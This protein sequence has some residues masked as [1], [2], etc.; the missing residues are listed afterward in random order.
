MHLLTLAAAA[1]FAVA[2]AGLAAGFFGVALT[3]PVAPL[4][5]AVA[6]AAA[7]AGVGFGVLEAVV[8]VV[9]EVPSCVYSLSPSFSVSTAS[10]H[11]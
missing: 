6:V 9:A 1:T 5:F 3:L 8:V 10:S 7:G 11:K 4:T 2:A